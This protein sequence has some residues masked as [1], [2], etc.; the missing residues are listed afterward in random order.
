MSVCHIVF[1]IKKA[2][3]FVYV[4]FVMLQHGCAQ[5]LA[6]QK[7]SVFLACLYGR[8]CRHVHNFNYHYLL[9]QFYGFTSYEFL[10]MYMGL[11]ASD[12]VGCSPP[13]LKFVAIFKGLFSE[14]ARVWADFAYICIQDCMSFFPLHALLNSFCARLD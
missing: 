4:G 3:A 5:F 7:I 1:W 6:L 14:H 9:G 2:V 8:S 11:H 10:Q 12:Q 13:K